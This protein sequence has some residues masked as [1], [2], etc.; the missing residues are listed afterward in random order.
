MQTTADLTSGNL[1]LFPGKTPIDQFPGYKSLTDA[2]RYGWTYQYPNRDKLQ[3]VE[4]MIALAPADLFD[5][6]FLEPGKELFLRL[7]SASQR[8]RRRM[9]STTLAKIMLFMHYLIHSSRALRIE[10]NEK[11]RAE[12]PAVTA[13]MSA[14]DACIENDQAPLTKAQISSRKRNATIMNP[15]GKDLDCDDY[16]SVNGKGEHEPSENSAILSDI[17]FRS[18]LATVPKR[19]RRDLQ[20]EVADFMSAN[21]LP[22]SI[23]ID[24]RPGFKTLTNVYGYKYMNKEKRQIV[25]NIIALTPEEL[26]DGQYVEPGK[27]LLLLLV[28]AHKSKRQNTWSATFLAKVMLFMHYLIRSS[29]AIRTESSEKPRVEQPAVTALMTAVKECIENEQ[30]QGPLAQVSQ[31]QS[32]KD[33]NRLRKK[34]AIDCEHADGIASVNKPSEHER[35][36][37]S[38]IVVD[39][40]LRSALAPILKLNG[41]DLHDDGADLMPR[42]PFEFPGNIPIDQLPGYRSLTIAHGCTYKYT[43]HDKRQIVEN[44]IAL[45][46]EDLFD[47]KYLV[48]GK[49]LFLRLVSA[50]QRKRK[51]MVTTTLARIML[52]VHFLIRSSRAIRVE[53]NEKLRAEQPAVTALM[54]AV[55]ACIEIDQAQVPQARFKG[56]HDLPLK[57]KAAGLE[58]VEVEHECVR[59]GGFASVNEKRD[60]DPGENPTVLVDLVFGSLLA[61]IPTLIVRDLLDEIDDV[62]SGHSSVFPGNIPIDRL[63]G[64]KTLTNA[65]RFKFQNKDKRQIVENTIALA[66]EELFDGKYLGPGKQLFLLMVSA[67]K[68]KRQRTWSSAFLAK[69]MLF[70]YYLIRSSRAIR[71]ESTEK[72]PEEP[73]VT[74]LITAVEEGIKIDQARVPIA[75][76]ML[77][78]KSAQSGISKRGRQ[79][80]EH[81]EARDRKSVV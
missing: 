67:S 65:Y 13:L 9:L 69:I 6:K 81:A 34:N 59:V 11:P 49:E 30:A 15:D 48:T 23:P 32:T 35:R 60:Q 62:I 24:Q 20:D 25:G 44:I 42:N 12:Q 5:G 70:I 14:V 45:A 51:S 66:P 76:S 43:N 3:I 75:Q 54:S 46:P 53:C 39:P 22:G 72:P 79:Q 57:T 73:A 63:A 1:S 55:D 2:Y 80:C 47:G 36:K 52:Y 74:A 8:K 68:R 31:A 19:I 41:R 18:A 28:T 7:I 50:S 21:P 16:T 10:R 29:R 40:L 56:T 4:N 64:F 77:A 38:A 71:A 61:P 17:F 26:F 58:Q 37:T 27:Q 33:Q 78:K